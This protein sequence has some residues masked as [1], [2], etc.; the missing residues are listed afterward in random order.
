MDDLQALP[1]VN[2]DRWILLQGSLQ[3]IVAHLPLSCQWTH[4]AAA[5]QQAKSKAVDRVF[6][7]LG[8]PRADH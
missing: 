2:Q 1:L 3:R 8:L 5:V 6:T 4:V 7:I